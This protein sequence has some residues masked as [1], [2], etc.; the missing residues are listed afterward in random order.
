MKL[1][2]IL[3]VILDMNTTV[4][5][6]AGVLM[7]M[8]MLVTPAA[9]SSQTELQRMIADL[10]TQVQKLQTQANGM[11]R[12]VDDDKWCEITTNKSSYKV[13]EKITV[14]WRSKNFVD[15]SL[16]DNNKAGGSFAVEASG[17]RKFTTEYVDTTRGYNFS[18]SDEYSGYSHDFSPL[19]EVSVPVYGAT[20]KSTKQPAAK[21]VELFIATPPDRDTGRRYFQHYETYDSPVQDVYEVQLRPSAG[22]VQTCTVAAVYE[23]KTLSYPVSYRM[24]VKEGNFDHMKVVKV[25]YEEGYGD[26]RTLRV[27]C[28]TGGGKNITDRV[29]MQEYDETDESTA[30]FKAVLNGRTIVTDYN[31]TRYE[32]SLMCNQTANQYSTYHFGYGD[33]LKCYWG[34]TLIQTIDAWKG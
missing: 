15:P 33:V 8:C 2:N 9:A 27:S 34:T 30:T 18:L 12:D 7:L 1:I 23:S 4:L 16:Q 22:Y 20:R 13:G 32:A 6:I 24:N 11:D 31:Q 25:P 10:L 29:T 21:S 14:S 26:L 5:K 17:S 19:C 28:S 3:V